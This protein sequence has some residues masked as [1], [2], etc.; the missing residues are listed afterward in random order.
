[1][2]NKSKSVCSRVYKY[3]QKKIYI[4]LL[5]GYT[6]QS[7][8]FY[9]LDIIDLVQLDRLACLRKSLLLGIF[10]SRQVIVLYL[11]YFFYV[12]ITIL[13][14]H[15]LIKVRVMSRIR[16]FGTSIAGFIIIIVYNRNNKRSSSLVLFYDLFGT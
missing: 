1:L 8:A 14:F 5:I 2:V 13:L 9:L 16:V 7:Y 11:L 3:L 15:D 12:T 10:I 6:K 4:Y